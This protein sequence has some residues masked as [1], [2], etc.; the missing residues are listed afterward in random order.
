MSEK[1]RL[2]E[3]TRYIRDLGI[4]RVDSGRSA[5]T[6]AP[7]AVYAAGKSV[8]AVCT[9]VENHAPEDGPLIVTRANDEQLQAL[10]ALGDSVR[11]YCEA[12]LASVGQAE[13][14][15]CRVGVIAA[16]TS[17]RPVAEEAACTLEVLGHEVRR[18][19]D[20]GVAGLH[21]VL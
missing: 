13:A 15:G 2:P 16:G 20:V 14:S 5:R 4:A 17:D 21:R 3:A 10:E 12:R 11:V 6:G 1:K 18:F 19:Y 7:E 9:L 8:E